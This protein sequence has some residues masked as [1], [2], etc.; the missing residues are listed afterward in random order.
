MFLV[1]ETVNDNGE[2]EWKVAPKRWVCTTKNTRRTV[3]LWPHEIS[4]ERQKQLARSGSSKPMKNWS[5]KECIVQQECSTYDIAKAVMIEL[6]A[7]RLPS[8]SGQPSKQLPCTNSNR[9]RHNPKIHLKPT[10]VPDDVSYAPPVK[11][12]VPESKASMLNS[13][14]TMV[15]SLMK[16][17]ACIEKQNSRIEKQN[18]KIEEQN[19][20]IENESADL[21]K[22]LEVMQKRLAILGAQQI[23]TEN[24]S[25]EN[26]SFYIDPAETFAQLYDLESKLSDEAFRS[27]MVV[28]LTFNIVG[29]T[30]RRRMLSCLDLLFSPELLTKCSWIGIHRNG[31]EKPALK[32]NRNVLKLFK[33]IGSTTHKKINDNEIAIF[34]KQKLKCAKYRLQRYKERAQRNQ[35][36]DKVATLEEP[37]FNI[38][39]N[40]VDSSNTLDHTYAELVEDASET[41]FEVEIL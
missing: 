33:V 32:D 19:I 10:G 9:M 14:K 31:I 25:M 11:Q 13:I 39:V 6:M 35:V 23:H 30:P 41:P 17:H 18:A 8:N 29:K 36:E 26:S 20:R 37:E 22:T 27:K 34:F 1:V 24:F 21:K 28:W 5:R 12:P 4:S 7:Q 2:K 40:H 38:V 15:E 3:L 16:R